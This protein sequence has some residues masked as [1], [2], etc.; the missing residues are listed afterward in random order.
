MFLLGV[1][2]PFEVQSSLKVSSRVGAMSSM[3]LVCLGGKG[4]AARLEKG[5]FSRWRSMKSRGGWLVL[6]SEYRC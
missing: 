5:G 3:V 4:V 6:S 2:S 1:V